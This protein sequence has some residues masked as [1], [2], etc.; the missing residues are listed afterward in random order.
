MGTRFVRYNHEPNAIKPDHSKNMMAVM[1][2]ILMWFYC[3]VVALP[4]SSGLA[5][6]VYIRQK[7]NP[8]VVL[9]AIMLTTSIVME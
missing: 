5:T 6:T 8:I 1:E 4:W 3:W 2:K 7:L 9:I